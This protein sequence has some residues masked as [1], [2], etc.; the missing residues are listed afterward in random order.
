MG[1][2]IEKSA[3]IPKN[4]KIKGSR[5]IKIG[6]A[7]KQT[8]KVNKSTDR[9]NWRNLDLSVVKEVDKDE[10]KA[11]PILELSRFIDESQENTQKEWEYFNNIQ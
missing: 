1:P 4:P 8:Q 3:P 9:K 10:S 11:D 2:L 5:V 7:K 6:G